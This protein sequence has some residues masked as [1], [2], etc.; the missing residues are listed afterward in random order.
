[1]V[2]VATMVFIMFY[3]G[4]L[5][6]YMTKLRMEVGGQ[7]GV[8]VLVFS[9]FLV[10]I[11]DVGAYFSGRLLGRH[12]M[13]PW[14]SPKKTWEG[15]VGGIVL[16][17]LCAVAGGGWLRAAGALP[18]AGGLVAAPWDLLILGG[19]M[20]AF[21]VAG[22]LCGSLLKRDADAKDS[23]RLLPGMGGML[24]VLDSPLLAAPVA[25][26]FWTRIVQI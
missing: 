20:A 10:K 7:D 24:D 26:F 25:W 2:N 12:K 9:I 22:D 3:T 1:M 5:A 23:G 18:G 15:L 4:G 17:L 13:I 6:G 16:A 11:T 21:S 19:L 8:A 14:L